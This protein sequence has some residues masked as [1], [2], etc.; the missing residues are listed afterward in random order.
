LNLMSEHVSNMLMA[1]RRRHMARA[2]E[3]ARAFR[4]CYRG[5]LNEITAVEGSW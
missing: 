3:H 2:I 5:M 4:R 1:A